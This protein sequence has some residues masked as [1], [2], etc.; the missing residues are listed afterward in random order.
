LPLL[1][2]SV[3]SISFNTFISVLTPLRIRNNELYI[4]SPDSSTRETVSNR[5]MGRI[6]DAIAAVSAAGGFE[7]V[8]VLVIS[9]SDINENGE[10]VAGRGRTEALNRPASNIKERYTFDTFVK[11]KGNELAFGA[12]VAVSERPG[13]AYNPLFLYGGVGLGKT[14]LMHAIGNNALKRDPF[15]NVLYVTSEQMM[16]EF[17]KALQEKRNEEFRNKYRELDVLLIDDIQFLGDKEG[18]QEEFFH[19]FNTLYDAGKQIVITS[20]K[21]PREL[22]GLEERL[23][24]RFG[25]G[26]TA[27]MILPDFE[28]RSAIL[29]KKAQIDNLN[30]PTEIIRYLAQA[31]ST[32]IR[33]LEGAFIKLIANAKLTNAHITFE[34]AERSVAEIRSENDK[35]VIDAEYIQEVT[36]AH[37]KVPTEE[38]K[39]RKRTADV[40]FARHVAMYV[41]RMLL[42]IPLADIGQSFGGKD[43]TTVI[44]GCNKISAELEGNEKLR[45]DVDSIVRRLK[46]E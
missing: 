46:G 26:L 20:D 10:Y 43:H 31:V 29:E 24:S 45:E 9:K 5:Y 23:V 38:L 3:G 30:I 18:T 4:I 25:S 34:L 36:A 14:H 33:E 13:Q 39:S 1:E 37:F 11:G 19:T 22:K 44:H 8:S 7:P 2:K 41:C 32:N 27:D 16:N 17:I 12:S 28:T 21:H 35:K 40:A 42:T 6:N 15:A